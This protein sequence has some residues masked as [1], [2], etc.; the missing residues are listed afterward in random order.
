ME[1][2]SKQYTFAKLREVIT[3]IGDNPKPPNLFCNTSIPV[4][5]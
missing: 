4:Y 2:W 1:K 3:V 5:T